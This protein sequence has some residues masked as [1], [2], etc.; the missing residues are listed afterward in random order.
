MLSLQ[1]MAAEM[2]SFLEGNQMDGDQIRIICADI[3]QEEAD[4]AQ[5]KISLGGQELSVVSVEKVKNDHIPVTYYCLVD[6]SGSMNSMQMEQAKAVLTEI[7]GSLQTDD[8]MVIGT[9]G[10]QTSSTGVISD[11]EELNRLI[12][13]LEPGH[14]DTNLYAG[15][16]E[17]IRW[18]Q[19][20]GSVNP[21]KCLVILSDGRDDQK[22]G[23]T[24][25]EADAAV[26]QSNIPVYTVATLRQ[27]P[28]DSQLEDAKILGSF[29]RMSTGG[30]HYAPVLEGKVGSEI[31]T[32]LME[33]MDNGIILTA[34]LSGLTAMNEKDV[35]LLRVIYTAANG[36][37]CEDSLELYAEDIQLLKQVIEPSAE[38]S[39]EETAAET[40]PTEPETST[41]V[42][43]PEDPT[44][45]ESEPGA[46]VWIL[47]AAAVVAAVVLLLRRK[48]K[49]PS[50]AESSE[51]P[52]ASMT[53]TEPIRGSQSVGKTEPVG[54]AT[55]FIPK[56]AR[57]YKLR[58]YAIGYGHIKYILKLEEG[59]DTTIGRTD[60]AD[61]ILDSSDKKL[62]AV[63]CKVRWE[64]GKLYVWDM[65]SSNGTF[66]NGVPIRDFGRVLVRDGETIRMGSYE[67]RVGHPGEEK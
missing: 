37:V 65:N 62:S 1:A 19:T 2:V 40:V 44:E 52:G 31:G 8:N 23:I 53:R 64:D 28:S 29:A 60:K 15:I 57:K 13:T 48:G 25:A 30:V 6:V 21:R 59:K 14:E 35:W 67:Y 39:T 33:S 49:E 9:L 46:A 54:S 27:S 47:M 24:K 26:G 12:T 11:Q 42:P 22:T 32:E 4:A 10:N 16:V 36:T 50:E 63:H 34:D 58:L 18:L 41:E 38:E 3:F 55:L 66:V 45:P 7:C 56:R 5:F 51:E 20:D 43:L 17:S 61:I